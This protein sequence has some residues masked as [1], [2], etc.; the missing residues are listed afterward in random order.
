MHLVSAFDRARPRRHALCCLGLLA[1][2]II[3]IRAADL[4]PVPALGLRVA[5]GFE[6]TLYADDNLASDIYAMTLD[7]RGNVVVTS[8][9]Y[10]R[11]LEDRNGDGFADG[12]IEFAKT[13]TGGMGMCFDGT[14]LMFVGEGGLWRYRDTNDDGR[15]DGAPER[16]LSLAFGEHGGHA[17]RHGP[18]GAWYVMGGNDT[19]FDVSQIRL[20]LIHSAKIAGGALVRLGSNGQNP[21]VFA[22]GFRN[23]Y[24]FDFNADGDLFTYD[25]DVERDYHLPWYSP[26]RAYHIAPGG[27][28]GW[29]LAGHQRSWARKDYYPDTVEILQPLDRGSPTGVACYEHRQF[30]PYYRGGLFALDWTFGRVYFLPLGPQ[31][32]TYRATPEVFLE[33]IGTQGFAPTDAAVG[34]D[35]S[36]FIS[37]GGRKT[38]GAIYRI[39]SLAANANTVPATNWPLVWANSFEAI[40]NA[41]Q[42]LEAWS[43]NW[44][45]PLARQAG[46]E[47]FE[48]VAADNR[49][50][51]ENRVRAIEI[52]TEVHGGLATAN[53]ATVAQANSPLIRARAAWS[54]GAIPP[55]GFAPILLG[56]ARDTASNVRCAALEA[57]H[58]HASGV[59]VVTLQQAL[60]ANLGHPDKR[61]RQA[62]GLLA[63]DLPEP[64][65]QALW[66]QQRGGTP[67]SRLTTGLAHVWRTGLDQINTNAIDAALGVLRQTLVHDL[68]SQAVRL[69]QLGLGDYHLEKPSVEVYTAYEPALSLNGSTGLVARIQQTLVGLFPSGDATFNLEA[70]RLLAM[71]QAND[72]TVP[73]KVAAFFVDRSPPSADFHYLIVFSRL[74]SSAVTNHTA[75]IAG[76]V[77]S[78]DR[79]LDGLQQRPKQNWN[80]R[81]VEVVRAL[82]DNDPRLAGALLNHPDFA[83]AGHLDIVPL[84]GPDR[85]TVAAR[86]FYNSVQKNP[87]F[88][89]SEALVELLSSL[90]AEDTHPLFRRQLANVTLRDRLLLELASQPH[91]EDREY[92][93]AGLGSTELET[94]RASMSALLQLP[95]DTSTKSQ[96]ATLQLLRRLFRDP[97][98]QTARAQ[99]LTL[100][101]KLSGQKFTVHETA[102]LSSSYQPVFDWFGQR[103]PGIL[104]RLDEEQE[105]PARWDQIYKATPWARGDAARGQA[106]FENRGCAPCH[107]GPRPVGPD[108][109]GAATRFSP[110][111]LF[112]SIVFPSRDVAP[113]Y[114]TTTYQMRDAQSYSGFVSYLSAEG[115]IVQ[116][117]LGTSVRLAE[118]D[119]VSRQ[120]GTVSFMPAGLLAGLQAQDLADLYA[121]LK[122]L[123]QGR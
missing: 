109:A 43:R 74:K 123:Q 53:A 108:L 105:S 93:V 96:V 94:V 59:N 107:S 9:G 73:E 32:S 33:S 116:T 29:R 79:K 122:T 12:S 63:T 23:P 34:A 7:A 37:A 106:I 82:L 17:V 113:A 3:P 11:T 92:F 39:R 78:L 15:A 22:H 2:F 44:W 51:A 71:I 84:L 110:T 97:K 57:L 52:L 20:G 10:I 117:G 120:P 80:V 102:D 98:A 100:L 118:E 38:R 72:S 119:I 85:Y 104:A 45:V 40:L 88:P 68:R 55:T 14:D 54:I 77:L 103:Y 60:G 28:H 121:Y 99:A 25:S 19:K 27:H 24:D 81:L 13:T 65:W 83:R 18:D 30:P 50:L 115:V 47:P 16:L 101:T 70:G 4:V 62:A 26:T 31:G 48:A 58:R 64:A 89:W 95:N 49:A 41:P 46:P 114:R 21:E 5:R 61:V 91:N 36:L 90:P 76:A 1:V 75:N 35:G 67:Q 66:N 87:A 6:V 8:Q 56:L 86:L 69:V 42:P 111:D 112:N